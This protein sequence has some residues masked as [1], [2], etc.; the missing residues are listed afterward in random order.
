MSQIKMQW[1]NDK[2]HN[3]NN[4]DGNN[5]EKED[6][7]IVARISMDSAAAILAEHASNDSI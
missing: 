6:D 7:L 4:D 5:Y 2:G 1:N 3:K